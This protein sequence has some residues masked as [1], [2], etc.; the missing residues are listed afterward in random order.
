VA[1]QSAPGQPL[2]PHDSSLGENF[3]LSHEHGKCFGDTAL[4]QVTASGAL[5]IKLCSGVQVLQSLNDEDIQFLSESQASKAPAQDKLPPTSAPATEAA[6]STAAKQVLGC[7]LCTYQ[8][9]PCPS[10]YHCC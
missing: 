6:A 9:A 4:Q 8:A 10:P 3:L 5:L 7:A 2:K 1:F